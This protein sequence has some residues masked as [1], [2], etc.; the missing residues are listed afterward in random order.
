MS[1]GWPASSQSGFDRW[2]GAACCLHC[3]NRRDAGIDTDL[4][5]FSTVLEQQ[6]AVAHNHMRCM[7]S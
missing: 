5:E 6:I 1:T 4:G 7:M 2:S 3:G